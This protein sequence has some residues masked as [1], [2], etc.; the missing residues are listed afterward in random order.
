MIQ[1]LA[2]RLVA[3]WIGKLVIGGFAVFTSVRYGTGVY[4]WRVT[5]KLE[6]PSYTVI[7]KLS[8]GAELRRYEPYLIAETTFNVDDMREPTK[9]GFRSCAGY[10]FGK[11]IPRT[12]AAVRIEGNSAPVGEKMVWYGKYKRFV[13]S[14]I[15]QSHILSF[16]V[17]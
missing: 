11:N 4:V 16:A 7:E 17:Y 14:A 12:T 10:I 2:Q 13:V 5:E 15:Y 8:D 6:R 3:G 1:D 9:E